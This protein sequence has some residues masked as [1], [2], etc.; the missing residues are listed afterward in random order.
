MLIFNLHEENLKFNTYDLNLIDLDSVSV[1][2][3]SLTMLDLI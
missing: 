2:Q 3:S 1:V